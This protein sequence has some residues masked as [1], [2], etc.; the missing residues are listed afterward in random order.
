MPFVFLFVGAMFLT[1]ALR[2]KTSDMLDIL[3][4]EFTGTN[5]FW[6]WAIG[7]FAVGS[8]GYVK[9]LQPLAN[10]FLLLIALSLLLSNEGFFARLSRDLRAAPSGD[11][12]VGLPQ[13]VTPNGGASN[14]Q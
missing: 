3:K 12:S 4:D 5:S 10:A 9:P 13:I 14:G 6:K 1:A 8:I 2:G 7:I 11:V